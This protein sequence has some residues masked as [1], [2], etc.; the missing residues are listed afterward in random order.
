MYLAM[1]SQLVMVAFN[2]ISAL[3]RESVAG[4]SE[5]KSV[6][7]L[8]LTIGSV[9]GLMLIF[10]PIY[11]FFATR[12]APCFAMTIK[13]RK[14]VFFDAWNVSRGRFWPILGAFLII[15]I[16]GGI[17]ASVLG[18]ILQALLMATT[19]NSFN[20]VESGDD[21]ARIVM[22]PAFIVP[23]GIYAALRLALTGLLQHVTGAPAAFAARHDPRGG[24]DDAANISIFD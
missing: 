15:S 1:M 18:Q 24:V 9:F 8:L 12:L 4:L 6:E 23:M 11:A 21:L 10:F 14:I 19:M 5:E 20:T 22:S 3:I 2:G 16:A 7:R 17:A 13:D